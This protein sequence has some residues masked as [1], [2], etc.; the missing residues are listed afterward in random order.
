M[1]PARAPRLAASARRA[2]AAT[3]APPRTRTLA[4]GI[5]SAPPTGATPVDSRTVP[6]TPGGAPRRVVSP[7]RAPPRGDETPPPPIAPPPPPGASGAAGGG[8]DGGGDGPGADVGG[9]SE[10]ERLVEAMQPHVLKR[11]W[12]SG[13]VDA[14]LGDLGWSPAAA[15]LLG[16]RGALGAPGVLVRRWNR[17]LAASLADRGGDEVAQGEAAERAASAI[18]QRVE[19]ATPLRSRW[20]EALQILAQPRNVKASAIS[21]AELADE[22]AHYAGYRSPDVRSLARGCSACE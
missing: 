3:R 6:A 17:E 15:G 13:A 7:D 14:A 21:S 1:L 8:R 2:L 19:M 5:G 4:S 16:R 18:R 9:L 11:G 20:S 12:T 22:I 10:A